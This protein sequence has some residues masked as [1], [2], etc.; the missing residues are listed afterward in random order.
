VGDPETVDRLFQGWFRSELAPLMIMDDVDI[1]TV[2]N[3]EENY[4]QE[5]GFPIPEGPRKLYEQMIE[6]GKL[7]RKVWKRILQLFRE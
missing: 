7:G 2:L 3:I 6:D 4:A 5:L 1:D